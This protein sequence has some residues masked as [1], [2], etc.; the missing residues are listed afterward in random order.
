MMILGFIGIGFRKN[1]RTGARF[2]LKIIADP[3]FKQ[4][5]AFRGG[6]FVVPKELCSLLITD[7]PFGRRIAWGDAEH[8]MTSTRGHAFQRSIA[9]LAVLSLSHATYP[10]N[11][12]LI[13]RVNS[14]FEGIIP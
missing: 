12:R 13:R 11:E 7:C 2:R 5:A 8:S 3:R 10:Q 9:R 4:K 1:R 6:F 14:G